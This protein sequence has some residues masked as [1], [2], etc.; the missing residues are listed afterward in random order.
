MIKKIINFLVGND[1]FDLNAIESHL[2][3]LEKASDERIAA[4]EHKLKDLEESINQ[5][6][7]DIEQLRDKVN[8]QEKSLKRFEN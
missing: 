8:R 4:K 5:K 6:K 1:G 3:A 7:V 2:D